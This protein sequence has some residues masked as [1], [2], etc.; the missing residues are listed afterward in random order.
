VT[1]DLS[2][3]GSSTCRRQ[4]HSNLFL[5]KT[6]NDHFFVFGVR[7][8]ILIFLSGTPLRPLVQ[9]QYTYLLK[10]ILTSDLNT[11]KT[12]MEG[13]LEHKRIEH[14]K[15]IFGKSSYLE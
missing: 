4:K 15:I 12:S 9:L 1:I 10:H 7:Q 11:L 3:V 2:Y 5:T 14:T 8:Q 6:T 13:N